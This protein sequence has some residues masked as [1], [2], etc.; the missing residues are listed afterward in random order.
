MIFWKSSYSNGPDG[1]ENF[2]QFFGLFPLHHK[3]FPPGWLGYRIVTQV[4]Y[5]R[6]PKPTL[7]VGH[8]REGKKKKNQKKSNLTFSR[9]LAVLSKEKR[10]FDRDV[11]QTWALLVG[12][13]I[14]WLIIFSLRIQFLVCFWRAGLQQC[15]LRALYV[16]AMTFLPPFLSHYIWDDCVNM[17][18]FTLKLF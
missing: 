17:L 13:W 18:L 10:K 4:Q 11:A 6:S 15:C 1:Q 7:R 2:H 16:L 5:F 14:R 9:L 8:F 3:S 12:K